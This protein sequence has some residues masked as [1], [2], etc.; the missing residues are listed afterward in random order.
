MVHRQLA[1]VPLKPVSFTEQIF[2]EFGVNYRVS[3]SLCRFCFAP[4]FRVEYRFGA[5]NW[6]GSWLAGL[7]ILIYLFE[8]MLGLVSF[9]P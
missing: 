3:S 1:H 8:L 9:F 2:F 5:V 6:R 7:Y 4:R